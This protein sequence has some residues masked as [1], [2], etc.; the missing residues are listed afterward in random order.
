LLI[1]LQEFDWC[2]GWDLNPRRPEPKDLKSPTIDYS[3]YKDVFINWLKNI[4]GLSS[5]TIKQRIRYLDKF[6]RPIRTPTELWNIF[7]SDLIDSQKRHL[8]NGYRSLFRFYEAQGWANK[9]RCDILRANLPKLKSG[10]DLNVPTEQEICRSLKRINGI[11]KEKKVFT[12]YNLLLDS[13]LRLVEGIKLLKDYYSNTLNL[14]KQNGFYVAPL[15]NFRGTKLAYYGFMSDYTLGLMKQ[16]NCVLNY[17]KTVGGIGKHLGVVSYKYLRKFAFDTMTS[18][19][20]NIP[21]SVADFIQG[22]TPKTV[23]ARHYMNLKRKAVNF[24]SRYAN[25]IKKLRNQTIHMSQN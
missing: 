25:Y 21:E 13:G 1:F 10:I 24:Y 7:G 11:K 6:A 20:L 15:A 4:K 17:K 3:R 22:R 19:N 8:A 2:G 12:L 9:Q 18:E 23:G 14:E 5:G 16:N